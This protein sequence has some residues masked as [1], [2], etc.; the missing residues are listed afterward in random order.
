MENIKI[1]VKGN[2][3]T[4]T[5]D[6]TKEFGTS[7]SGKTKVVATTHGTVRIPGHDGLMIGL[8]VNQK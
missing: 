7:K 6:L 5:V 3:M 1:E 2:L 4:L 8:N